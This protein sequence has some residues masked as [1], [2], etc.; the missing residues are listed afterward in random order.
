MKVDVEN[1]LNSSVYVV[2]R[3]LGQV[4]YLDWIHSTL[5]G[6]NGGFIFAGDS[7]CIEV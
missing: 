7:V 5:E 1:S 6:H 3:R 4:S 2:E